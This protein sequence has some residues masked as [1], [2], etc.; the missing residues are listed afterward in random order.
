M[1]AVEMVSDNSPGTPVSYFPQH[2]LRAMN[3]LRR[4]LLGQQS[5]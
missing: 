3:H 5:V 1:N 2:Q 4:L